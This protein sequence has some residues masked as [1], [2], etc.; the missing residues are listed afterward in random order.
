MRTRN[1]EEVM[2][3]FHVWPTVQSI[4]VSARSDESPTRSAFGGIAGVSGTG[5]DTSQ[6]PRDDPS[7]QHHHEPARGAEAEPAAGFGFSGEP[8]QPGDAQEDAQEDMVH[9]QRV[10]DATLAANRL[11]DAGIVRERQRVETG[12][13]TV[14]VGLL[15]DGRPGEARACIDAL[16][17]H[18][19]AHVLALDLG[20]VDGAGAV[21]HAEAESH[22]DRI[23]AWHVRQR[24]LWREGTATWSESRA[25]LLRLDT[26]DVHVFMDIDLAIDGDAITPLLAEINNGAMAAG[27][28]DPIGPDRLLATRRSAAFRALPED[29]GQD[30]TPLL[31]D[32]LPGRATVPV[33][34]L[35]G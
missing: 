21:L 16:I 7:H 8:G 1:E 18:T 30:A 2:T 6:A 12:D 19:T 23:T 17:A 22:P 28:E 4:P 34:A 9:A 24:P 14:T 26:A 11:D 13:L 5:R 35:H 20:D 33:T 10:W 27:W 31:W 32:A 15:I 29:S 25:K 3:T